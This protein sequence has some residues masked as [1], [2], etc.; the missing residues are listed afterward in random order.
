MGV[1][2]LYKFINKNC[3]EIYRNVSIYD[4]KDKSCIIDGMQHIYTQL[5]Y[6]RSKNKEIIT[7]T[8][9]NISHIHGLINSLTYYLKNGIVPIFIFDGKSPDIK[10]KKIEERK[11][12]LKQNLKKLKELESIKNDIDDGIKN[13]RSTTDTM[14]D[15]PDNIESILVGT[16]PEFFNLSDEMQK[17]QDVQDEYKKIYKK[18]IILKDYFVTDW[19]QILEFLGLPVIKA[20]GEA[21]PLCAYVLKNNNNVYGIIS[22]DSDMLVFGAPRLMRKSINQ[23]FTII[24]LEDLINSINKLLF[25]DETYTLNNGTRFEK[26]NLIDFSLLLGTDYAIFKLQKEFLDV[27]EMLKYYMSN[28]IEKLIFPDDIEKFYQIK[29][30]Y[31]NLEF[32]PAFNFILDKPV[33]NKPKLLELKKRLLELNVDEDFIDKN[34]EIFDNYYTKY[35]KKS[36]VLTSGDFDFRNRKH[37]FSSGKIFDNNYVGRYYS[38]RPP[39]YPSKRNIFMN[40]DSTMDMAT[41]AFGITRPISNQI[42]NQISNPIQIPHDKKFINHKSTNRCSYKNTKNIDYPDENYNEDCNEDEGENSDST[43][44]DKSNDSEDSDDEKQNYKLKSKVTFSDDQD[45]FDF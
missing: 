14:I 18:S 34:N 37:T 5:I 12:I 3:S 1:E 40:N 29:K 17:M 4:V 15:I 32:D 39:I 44:S 19:I 7:P 33:W 26:T 45:F 11:Q 35:L 36:N 31:E 16:P 24:E 8:G 27:Y 22:D 41:H 2:G 42:S 28:G 13:Y 25:S 21:D 9:K 6:M 10:K 30:Y 43:H 38:K 20:K 23:Q